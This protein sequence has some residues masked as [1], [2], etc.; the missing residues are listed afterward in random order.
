MADIDN[1][2]DNKRKRSELSS[3]SELDTS[4]NTSTTPN[5]EKKQKKKKNKSSRKEVDSESMKGGDQSAEP[6]LCPSEMNRQLAEINKKLSNVI[7]RDDGFLRSLIKEVFKQMK[8]ELLQSVS[9]RIDILEGRLFDKEEENDK[10]KKEIYTLNKEIDEQK[11]ENHNLSEQLETINLT[12]ESK[13]ND[14]EQYSRKNNIRI[15]G[16]PEIGIESAETTTGLVVQKLNSSIEALNLKID[17]IDVAHRLG[18]KQNG[19]HR[20]IIIKFHSRMKRDTILK[21][22]RVFKNTNIFV[23]EDLTKTNQHVLACIRKKSP[24]EVD[25]SWSKG[26]RLFYKA[27]SDPDTVIEVTFKEFQQWIDLPWPKRVADSQ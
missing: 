11:T 27:K 19:T 21:N 9:H 14:I 26:G 2:S 24:D 12:T 15:S 20:Q 25:R 3:I 4:G 1:E 18:K 22:R 5:K 17:D 8:D 23:S 13:L 6:G 10:L 16:I 7:T